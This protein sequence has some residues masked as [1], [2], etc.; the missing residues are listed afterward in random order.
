M[1]H[2][3]INKENW[4]CGVSDGLTLPCAVCGQGNIKFDYNVT[5]EL[6][7]KVV[8]KEIKRDVICLPCFSIMVNEKG[9]KIGEGMVS[10]QYTGVGETIEFIPCNIFNY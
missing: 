10:L 6:W 7:N 5:D 4:I 9:I 8:P 2:F 1:R 3:K